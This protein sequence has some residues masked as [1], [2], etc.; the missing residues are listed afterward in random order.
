MFTAKRPMITYANPPYCLILVGCEISTWAE[1]PTQVQYVS[2]LIYMQKH[3]T[4]QWGQV[5][6]QTLIS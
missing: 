4:A 5:K 2:I 1:L 3:A 6:T